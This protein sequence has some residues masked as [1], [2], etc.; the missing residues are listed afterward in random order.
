MAKLLIL[1]SF[2]FQEFSQ[3]YADSSQLG[4]IPLPDL[5]RQDF[6]NRQNSIPDLPNE[7]KQ[8]FNA[9]I[10]SHFKDASKLYEDLLAEGIAKECA[11]FVL[12]LATPTRISTLGIFEEIYQYTRE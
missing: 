5:R 12:P 7:I 2:T 10:A 9:K 4:N 11:R 3:R 1:R 8:R 6:K